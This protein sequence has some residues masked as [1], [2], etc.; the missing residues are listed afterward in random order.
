MRATRVGVLVALVLSA[1]ASPASAHRVAN[2]ESTWEG[3]VYNCCYTRH[4][5]GDAFRNTVSIRWDST[6]ASNM[7]HNR[8]HGEYFTLDAQDAHKNVSAYLI[9]TTI[10][11]PY[12]D[13]DDDDPADS[14]NEEAEVVSESTSFPSS[15]VW[16]DTWFRWS[17]S[18]VR[19]GSWTWDDDGGTIEFYENLSCQCWFG[20]KYNT[21]LCCAAVTPFKTYPGWNPPSALSAMPESEVEASEATVQTRDTRVGRPP[22]VAGGRPYT[23]AAGNDPND[24]H[25][26]AE[27]TGGVHAYAEEARALAA[28]VI[29]RGPSRGV[30]TF[31]RPVGHEVVAQLEAAGAI[32]SEIEAVS[33]QNTD[34]LR[35]TYFGVNEP[36]IWDAIAADADEQGVSVLGIIAAQVEMP[37]AAVLD[38]IQSRADVFL[39]DLAIEDYARRAAGFD[40]NMNDVFW[41]LAGWD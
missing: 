31:A 15:Y 25:L 34:G 22:E 28:S 17:H 32:V 2:W 11:S 8:S 18:F 21:A 29:E 3:T 13:F 23:A 37:D 35:W 12:T 9:S 36:G 1:F 6:K 19:N 20:D 27:M 30:L 41:K 39:V 10:L 5:S 7:R 40:V 16:Y 24:V 38:A 14:R 26:R 33:D 4:W